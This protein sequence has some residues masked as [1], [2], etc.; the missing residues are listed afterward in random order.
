MI[1]NSRQRAAAALITGIALIVVSDAAA[2]GS[3]ALPRTADGRPDLQGIWQVRNRAAYDLEDHAARHG[4]PAGR[5]VIDGGVIPYQPSAAAR[6]RDNFAKRATA[7]PLAECYMAGVPRII[8]GM[9]D[10]RIA[11]IRQQLDE[12]K[13][14][15]A[16]AEALRDEYARKAAAAEGDIEA[17]RASAERNAAEIVE[18]AKADAAAMIAR[19]QSAAAEKIAAAERG[20]VA[21]LRAKAASAAA[22]AARQLIAD[23]HGEDAD[24][25]LADQIISGI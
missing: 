21:E 14:L 5:S 16:E 15:R 11:G 9:L 8:A 25:K 1:F 18:K 12:A 24:R 4:M 2:Q 10:Q 17:M 6:K 19:H 3:A 23:K 22:T 13:A 7:D 20:A